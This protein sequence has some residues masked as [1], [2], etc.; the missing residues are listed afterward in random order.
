VAMIMNDV[1][2]TEYMQS[3]SLTTSQHSNR[4]NGIW[5]C[6]RGRH[7]CSLFRYM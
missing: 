5:T 1:G 4:C 2:L 6:A 7:F 3:R